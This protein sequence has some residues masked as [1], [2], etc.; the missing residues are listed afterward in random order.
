MHPA[1]GPSLTFTCLLKPSL[2]P[3]SPHSTLPHLSLP[4]LCYLS[5]LLSPHPCSPSTISEP[6]L[7]AIPVSV[8]GLACNLMKGGRRMN[9]YLASPRFLAL[10]WALGTHHPFSPHSIRGRD[11]HHPL[12]ILGRRKL[13]SPGSAALLRITQPAHMRAGFESGWSGTR[14]GTL[15]QASTAARREREDRGPDQCTVPWAEG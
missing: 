3:I 6:S 14:V 4:P 15:S 10:F 7:A 8:E 9:K 2:P 5:I 1:Q 13:S 11:R 12:S